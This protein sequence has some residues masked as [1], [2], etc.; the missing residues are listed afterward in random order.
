M[1][2]AC[3]QRADRVALVVVEAAF[4]TDQDRRRARVRRASR[5]ARARRPFRRRRT[6]RGRRAS[7]AAARRA[8]P[9]RRVRAAR[10][11]RIARPPRS[12]ARAAG[13]ALSRSTT[14]RRVS[15]GTSRATPSSHAFS[16]SQSIRPFLIGAAHS[17]RSG[18]GSRLAQLLASR[19]G[20]GR[21]CRPRSRRRAI[22]RSTSSNSLT[23]SPAFSRM[24][25]RADN[26]PAR[27]RRGPARPSAS[28]VSTNRRGVE[29]GGQAGVAGMS[30]C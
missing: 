18:T 10:C 24:H 22:R 7:R 21:A 3:G 26:A 27:P 5:R 29:R 2:T 8:S 20:S 14:V 12:C 11:G 19:R 6:A 15:T 1:P 28:G 9:A 13:R 23:G 4:G 30:P 25:R 17:H 16:A